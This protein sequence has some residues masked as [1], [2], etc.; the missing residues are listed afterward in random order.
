MLKNVEQLKEKLQQKQQGEAKQEEEE[1]SNLITLLKAFQYTKTTYNPRPLHARLVHLPPHYQFCKPTLSSITSSDVGTVVQIC[2]TVV[3]AGPIRMMEV[4][5]TYQCLN[6]DCGY[7]FIVNADFGTN[8][9]AL[10]MPIVC[11][12]DTTPLGDGFD[13]E[14]E[15]CRSTSFAIVQD[16]SDHC[17]YQ[18]IKIQESASALTRVGSIPRSI[19]IKLN[20]DLVDKCNPGDEVVVVGCLLAMWQNQTLGQDVECMVGMCMRAHSVRVINSE[21]DYGGGGSSMAELGLFG[22]KSALGGAGINLSSSG[23]LREKFRREFDAFWSDP[24][25][26]RRPIATRDYIVRAVCPKLYGMHAVKLGMLL[27]L[28]G[29][30]SISSSSTSADAEDK[31]DTTEKEVVQVE[32]DNDS[33]EGAPVAFDISGGGDDDDDKVGKKK[34]RKKKKTN[35][36]K[37]D[38]VK[39]RRRIQSRESILPFAPSFELSSVLF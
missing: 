36:S 11:P 1:I 21:E 25:A 6:K 39:T 13:D 26:R 14:Q 27:V 20:H 28:I 8:N 23:N 3:K 19:L 12:S 5:R 34:K 32:E 17:D 22:N 18:E 15:P 30:A 10:P 33:D 38:E 35:T 9:N 7:K 31:K 16:E 4:T 37:K 24:S 2:G 29:G